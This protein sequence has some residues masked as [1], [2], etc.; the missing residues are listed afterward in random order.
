M[1]SG[2][3]VSPTSATAKGRH[4]VELDC[5][6]DKHNVNIRFENVAKILRHDLSPRLTDFLEIAAYVFSADCATEREKAWTDKESTEPWSRD[7]A[8]VIPVR[9][10]DFWANTKIRKLIEEILRF[11]SNDKYSFTFEHLK[12]DRRAQP[13]FKFRDQGKWPFH[14]PDRVVMFSGGLDS[15]AGAVETAAAGSKLVL[16]SHRP[17]ST[18]EAR[19]RNLFAALRKHFPEQS[20]RIPVWI[21]KK[22]SLGKEPTQRTRSFLFTALGALVAHSI[23]AD[24]IRF[25]ENGVVSL[26]LPVA[27]EALR[28]RASRTT[29]PIALH[30]L[31]SLCTA[32]TER[33]L[34]VD[35]PYLYKT[36]TEVVATLA[37]HRT[38]DLIAYSC[39]CAHSMFK[40]IRQR[41]CGLCSQCID[42]RF[43]MAGANLLPY[44]PATDYE[45]DVFVGPREKDLDRAIAV[46]YAL[47][48]IELHRQP[49]G[50]LAA[51]KPRDQ[52]DDVR[53]SG[54]SG[55][56]RR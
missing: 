41:H 6:G 45:S 1:C 44:D 52:Q 15:L 43:A 36:K 9:D 14:H 34:V 28:A 20:V 40:P 53:N 33:T 16:V 26:N 38:E 27:Q 18:M 10:P 56:A 42:R 3:K 23:Q 30:L 12:Q 5:I 19:Q 51:S 55:R 2:A 24:G 25:Y 13:Y 46:D 29:H 47:H 31:A 48:G 49:E 22:E 17:V 7:L 11:L 54:C 37:R 21:N 32:V 35:N 39:S 50:R 8:F 4:R